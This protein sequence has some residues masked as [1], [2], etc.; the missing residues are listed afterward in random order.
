MLNIE[1]RKSYKLS[2]RI[3]IRNLERILELLDDVEPVLIGKIAVVA[4][5]HYYGLRYNRIFKYI[6]IAISKRKKKHI[7]EI[8]YD[9]TYTEETKYIEEIIFYDHNIKIIYEK[10]PSII[11]LFKDKKIPYNEI[12]LKIGNRKIK[13]RVAKLEYLYVDKI[14]TYLNE[15]DKQG[16][17][18]SIKV[19]GYL[20]KKYGYDKGLLDKIFDE[21]SKEYK[22]YSL[23]AKNIMEKILKDIKESDILELDTL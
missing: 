14:F 6:E 9:P 23:E 3:A 13:L 18:Y 17:F 10:G 22:K 12:E 4:Y 15:K 7:K 16:D 1:P 20:M 8:L 21:Y 11:I 2:N 5:E 19:L